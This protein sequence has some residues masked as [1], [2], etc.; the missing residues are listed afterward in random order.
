MHCADWSAILYLYVTVS[1]HLLHISSVNFL[2]SQ[3]GRNKLC[4]ILWI[5]KIQ[6]NAEWNNEWIDLAT[7]WPHWPWGGE[8]VATAI[9]HHVHVRANAQVIRHGEPHHGWMA[10]RHEGKVGEVGRV[11]MVAIGKQRRLLQIWKTLKVHLFS[12]QKTVFNSQSW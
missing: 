3:P 8:V 6:G 12:S 9:G 11:M 5:L 4:V 10:H 1:E 2:I 7:K